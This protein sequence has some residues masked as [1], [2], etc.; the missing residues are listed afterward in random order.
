MPANPKDN[1]QL[2]TADSIAT[3][4]IS[5]FSDGNRVNPDLPKAGYS[6]P[7]SKI[8]VG[9]YGQDW[10]DANPEQ[11]LHVTDGQLR[12][13]AEL[14][15]IRDREE[16]YAIFQRYAGETVTLADSRGHSMSTRGVR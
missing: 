9:P 15:A 1:T 12:R 7:R 11:P 4:Y 16:A 5:P 6:I 14:D 10:G 2:G 3:E 13:R 8:A